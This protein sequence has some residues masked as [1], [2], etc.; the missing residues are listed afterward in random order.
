MYTDRDLG[1]DKH[2]IRGVLSH[3]AMNMTTAKATRPLPRKQSRGQ[4]CVRS[5]KTNII[6]CDNRGV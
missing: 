2:N 1:P 6:N 4:L 5:I 3:Q